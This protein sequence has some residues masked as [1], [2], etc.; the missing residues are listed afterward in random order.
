MSGALSFSRD[1]ESS[2][3]SAHSSRAPLCWTPRLTLV[4]CRSLAGRPYAPAYARLL[5][6]PRCR[7][8]SASR[9]NEELSDRL[10]HCARVR[11]LRVV[12]AVGKLDALHVRQSAFEFGGTFPRHERVV[13]AGQE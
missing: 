3:G 5:P 7:G 2:E 10:R 11:V 8:Y 1:P 9:L 6:Q 4:C 13:V 12:A